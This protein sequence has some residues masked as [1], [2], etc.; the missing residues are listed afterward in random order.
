MKI[1]YLFLTLSVCINIYAQEKILKLKFDENRYDS[2]YLYFPLI[3]RENIKIYGIC[4]DNTWT[5]NVKDSV[6]EQ[7]YN[8]YIYFK[9]NDSKYRTCQ[10]VFEKKTREKGDI[11]VTGGFP[12]LDDVTALDIAFVKKNLVANGTV[13]THYYNLPD[14]NVEQFINFPLMT[15]KFF[16]FRSDTAKVYEEHVADFEAFIKD[17]PNSI[18]LL[19]RL[20]TSMVFFKTKEDVA[21]LYDCFTDEIKNSQYGK[22]MH[23]YLTTNGFTNIALYRAGENIMENVVIDSTK[24]NLLIFT[25]S[26]CA[27][28]FAEIPIYK[29]IHSNLG[30]KL[31][32]T[33]ISID[34]NEKTESAWLKQL[35]E[36]NIPWRLLCTREYMDKT[37]SIYS[38]WGIPQCILI[39]PGGYMEKIEVKTE[40]G[41][42]K[43]NNYFM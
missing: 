2:L 13:E 26:W 31:I 28:C 14:Y 15:T 24:Y 42:A 16:L 22:L 5:F 35:K 23:L 3:S 9:N 39:H 20:Y 1:F 30:D 41:R 12:L 7:A 37:M 18:L 4:K 40:K 34:K 36:Y 6:L 27:P 38:I 25:A 10:I 8:M 32:M 33:Y 19:N 29:E 43:L 17:Y 21:R 11:Y